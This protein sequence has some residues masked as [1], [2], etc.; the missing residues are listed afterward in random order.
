MR[1][2]LFNNIPLVLLSLG[3]GLWCVEL[4]G[5]TWTPSYCA[6][7]HSGT[8]Y[9]AFGFPLPYLQFGNVSSLHYNYLWWAQLFNVLFMSI[10]FVA[11]IAP[12]RLWSSK[13]A[14]I[15]CCVIGGLLIISAIALYFIYYTS[16]M[17]TWVA[18]LSEFVWSFSPIDIG[19]VEFAG[20]SC[21]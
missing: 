12:F 11:L 10:V 1:W 20:G 9:N 14:R 16:G 19:R 5:L 18:Q 17:L 3:C 21:P 4:F 8:G 7:Q 13:V 6:D 15:A 2:K